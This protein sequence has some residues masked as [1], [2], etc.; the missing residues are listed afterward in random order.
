MTPKNVAI[1]IALVAWFTIMSLFSKFVLGIEHPLDFTENLILA[2][3]G[4]ILSA[5]ERKP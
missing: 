1:F 2:C 3:T 4:T 5:L